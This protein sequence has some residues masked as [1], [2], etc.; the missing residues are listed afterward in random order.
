MLLSAL[1]TLSHLIFTARSVV[2][3]SPLNKETEGQRLSN[4]EEGGHE[5]GSTGTRL[6]LWNLLEVRLLTLSY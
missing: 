1:Y 6:Q 2:L 4:T 5:L 3:T